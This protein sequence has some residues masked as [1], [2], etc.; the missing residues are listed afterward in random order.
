M[1]FFFRQIKSKLR[2]G[3]E[4]LSDLVLIVLTMQSIM[5]SSAGLRILQERQKGLP[6]TSEEL[7]LIALFIGANGI[8]FMVQ[9]NKKKKTREENI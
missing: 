7:Q 4:V 2:Q 9:G 5:Y 8:A 3:H 1:K 6:L